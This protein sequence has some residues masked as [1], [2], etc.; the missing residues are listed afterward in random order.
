MAIARR[1][2]LRLV[3]L[4]CGPEGA[5]LVAGDEESSEPAPA[6][7]VVDTVGAGDAFAASVVCDFLRGLP[8]A[9]VN[10]KANEVAALVCAT[11]VAIR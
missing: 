1:Y 6:V 2:E 11:P 4:T 8:L 9:E 3:A 5:I 7:E 10:R